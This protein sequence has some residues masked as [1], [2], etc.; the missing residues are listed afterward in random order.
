MDMYRTACIKKFMSPT[1]FAPVGDSLSLGGNWTRL[2]FNLTLMIGINVKLLPN[3]GSRQWSEHSDLPREVSLIGCPGGTSTSAVTEWF[4]LSCELL[5][6]VMVKKRM[7]PFIWGPME[8]LFFFCEGLPYKNWPQRSGGSR[9]YVV[10]AGGRAEQQAQWSEG[11]GVEQR[12][13][14]N[15]AQDSSIHSLCHNL[16]GACLMVTSSGQNCRL[17]IF[18]AFPP[19]KFHGLYQAL[20]LHTQ[21]PPK[22]LHKKLHS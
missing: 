5:L 20:C 18:T 22:P 8:I 21:Y 14:A 13:R 16:R 12:E 6:Q 11:S 17:L 19:G 10:K 2:F 15:G 3:C 1:S 9:V 4:Q 7:G